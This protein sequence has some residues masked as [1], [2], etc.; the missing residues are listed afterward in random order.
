M[1]NNKGLGKFETLTL[2]VVLMAIGAFLLYNVLGAAGSKNYSKFRTDAVNFNKAVYSN[3]DTFKNPDYVTLAEVVSFNLVDDFKSPFSKEKCDKAESFVISEGSSRY[4]TLKC[5][6]YLIDNVLANDLD[7]APVFKVGEWQEEA[8]N[9]PNVQTAELYNCDSNGELLLDKYA[10][11]SYLV[12]QANRTFGENNYFP[13]D[14]RSCNV[15]KKT[16]YRTRELV[17]E[18]K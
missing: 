12:F 18:D 16:F 17:E 6:E 2:M 15:I 11:G 4:V 7:K 1:I 10:V 13:E 3:L 14:I 9:E 5:D 8:I